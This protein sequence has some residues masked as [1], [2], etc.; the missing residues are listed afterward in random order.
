MAWAAAALALAAAAGFS[1]RSTSLPAAAPAVYRFDVR[2][3]EG[4]VFPGANG[5]PR[6]AVSP[7]GAQIVFASSLPGQRDQLFVRRLGAVEAEPIKGTESPAGGGDSVQQPFFS[8]DGR[9]VA[10][11]S[12]QESALKRVPVGG[13]PV[14]RLASLPPQNCAGSWH[15][16]VKL[17]ACGATG[18]VQRLPASGGTLTP[19]TTLDA[20]RKEFAHLYPQFLPDGEHVL[21][22]AQTTD[23]DA[24]IYVGSLAGSAPVRVVKTEAMARFAPP[25]QLL[26][27]RDRALVSQTLDLS[28]FALVGDAITVSKSVMV[29]GNS[30][31]GVSTSDNGV[32]VLAQGT[33]VLGSDEILAR[34]R[35]GR[36]VGSGP[37]ELLISFGWARL[38]PDGRSV[39]FSRASGSQDHIWVK[40]LDRGVVSRVTTDEALNRSPV[41][42]RDGRRVT[43]VSLRGPDG[44]T[45]LFE[46][47]VA[48]LSA[49]R[50]LVRGERGDILF[51]E[52]WSPDGRTLVY[53]SFSSRGG[54][55]LMVLE[56][57]EGAVPTPYL[58]DGF[59]NRAASFSPDGRWL[60]YISDE[61]GT[62]QVF[63]RSFPDPTQAK[64]QVSADGGGYPRWR[65]DGGELYFVSARNRVTAIGVTHGSGLSFGK[66]VDLFDL[67]DVS[68]VTAV[69]SPFDVSAD[70]QRFIIVRPMTGAGGVSLTIAVNWMAGLKPTRP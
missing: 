59:N 18:G 47:D 37:L 4:Q 49:E 28:R 22:F 2:P 6:F 66:P 9:F 53:R 10:F 36:A 8:P 21:Y 29:A 51:P 55:D 16:D 40:N 41:W 25:N 17:V 31:I 3:P 20:S 50:L 46:R 39:A 19:V 24:A 48:A 69:R 65:G 58:R 60:A 5:V 43:Y 11:F 12:G 7:D 52:D 33:D 27:V 56:A 15:G 61:S 23:G 54:D 14:E 70:G 45:G 26:Y 35:A 1:V 13:G 30:R 34:D 64:Y 32:V 38:S 62:F 63:V 67:G 42:S 57:S 68:V 44:R